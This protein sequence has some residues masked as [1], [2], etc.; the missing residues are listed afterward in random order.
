MTSSQERTISKKDAWLAEMKASR[1]ETAVCQ[2]TPEANPGTMEGNPDETK[3]VTVI[4]EAPKSCRS[5]F[6]GSI[7]ELSRGSA[8]SCRVTREPKER[9]REIVDPGRS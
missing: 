3:S 6:F 5:E 2:E 8:T 7:E 9:T 1:K 4:E